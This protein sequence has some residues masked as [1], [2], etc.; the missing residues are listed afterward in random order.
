MALLEFPIIIISHW[1]WKECLTVDTTQWQKPTF[2]THSANTT[3]IIFEELIQVKASQNNETFLKHTSGFSKSTQ[4]SWC[5]AKRFIYVLEKKVFFFKSN[6][7]SPGCVETFRSSEF[8]VCS[9]YS[10]LVAICLQPELSTFKLVRFYHCSPFISHISKQFLR[11]S[12][13]SPCI[14]SL[15]PECYCG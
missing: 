12:P 13:C 7:S 14:I 10:I 1:I 8:V 15:Q 2:Q 5:R 9:Q 11:C 4:Q 3:W 6:F